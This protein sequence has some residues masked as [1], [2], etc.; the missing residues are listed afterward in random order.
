MIFIHVLKVV[1]N[2]IEGGTHENNLL[3]SSG[4]NSGTD[5][6]PKHNGKTCR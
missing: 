6:Y 1:K 5:I 4:F 2:S 3:F